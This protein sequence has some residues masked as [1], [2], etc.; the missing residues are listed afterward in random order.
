MNSLLTAPVAP[1]LT[2][3]FA[4]AQAADAPLRTQ[5]AQLAP[6]ARA[7]L[8]NR[9][10]TDYRGF[11]GMAKDMFLPVSPET[12]RLLYLL[13]RSTKARAV[14]EFGT[15]F[16]L[17]TLHLA[18]ALRD[19][20]GGRVIGSE[21]EAA[22]V[23]RARENLALAGLSEFVEIR[24]GD[25]TETLGRDL[26]TSVDFLL[27][28]GAKVLYPSILALVEP[29]LH[30]GSLIVADNADHN[31]EFLAYI[32]NP[33]NGYLSLPFADDVELFMRS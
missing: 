27:L 28:D 4:E 9:A 18:A 25:A 1:L 33:H 32:R 19:N 8:M 30:S 29:S 3:L 24:E 14:V 13:V 7:E 26:P 10:N 12:G 31:P 21:F 17:S 5:L 16:G 23:V 6:E 11:Y 15:S 20:G 22:K 2:R